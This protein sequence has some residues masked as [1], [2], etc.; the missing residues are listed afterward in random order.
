MAKIKPEYE[1]L[2]DFNEVAKAL[3]VKYPDIFADID[4][5]AIR[6][7][8]INNKERPEKTKPWELKPVQYPIRLD[9]DYAWYVT[10]YLNEWEEMSDKRRAIL[11]ASVLCGIGE[12]G[13]MNPFDLKDFD[14]MVRSF[15]LDYQDSEDVPD[16]I[17]DNFDWKVTAR[18]GR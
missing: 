14:L 15:G 11:V 2:E 13:K 17:N 18:G 8:C 7:Y 16:I 3:C 5:D 4:P 1:P 6:C 9:C 10:L 12:D